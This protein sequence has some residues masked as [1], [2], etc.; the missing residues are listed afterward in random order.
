M[1]GVLA[2]RQNGLLKFP[3]SLELVEMRQSGTMTGLDFLYQLGEPSSAYPCLFLIA[4]NH[5]RACELGWFPVAGVFT[6]AVL[7]MWA[8]GSIGCGPH[9]TV[10]VAQGRSRCQTL[11]LS[12]FHDFR[13]KWKHQFTPAN[14]SLGICL[15]EAQSS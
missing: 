12:R 1:F 15:Q 4:A 2:G 3:A 14:A 9:R 11:A 8:G 13:I 7:S 6:C 10:T 5:N